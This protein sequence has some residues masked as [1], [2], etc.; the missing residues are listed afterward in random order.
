M[1][2]LPEL[3]PLVGPPCGLRAAVAEVWPDEEGG[4]TT[5][6]VQLVIITFINDGI[7]NRAHIGNGNVQVA[8]SPDFVGCGL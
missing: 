3:E 6:P 5:S 7:P 4:Q 2:C 1:S 8:G